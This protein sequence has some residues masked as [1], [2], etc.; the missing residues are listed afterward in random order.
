VRVSIAVANTHSLAL[1]SA[2]SGSFRRTR[3][4]VRTNASSMPA[5]ESSTTKFRCP[6][7]SLIVYMSFAVND[8]A[9]DLL[10]RSVPSL[11]ILQ[12]NGWWP[13]GVRGSHHD[14]R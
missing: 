13:D 9:G 4:R 5:S 11:E 10:L 1:S 14:F 2:F 8:F 12:M 6:P 7:G 3:L